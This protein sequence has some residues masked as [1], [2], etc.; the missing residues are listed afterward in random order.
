MPVR[1]TC[2]VASGNK[3]ILHPALV[4]SVKVGVLS[5]GGFGLC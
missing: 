1:R 5:S 3:T 4:N 2:L